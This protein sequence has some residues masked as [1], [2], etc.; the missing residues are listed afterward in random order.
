MTAADF[1]PLV[2]VVALLAGPALVYH[3]RLFRKRN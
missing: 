3:Y 2:A 1:L